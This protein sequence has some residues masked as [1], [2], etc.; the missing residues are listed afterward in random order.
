MKNHSMTFLLEYESE[1]MCNKAYLIHDLYFG[2]V[3]KE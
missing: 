1:F 2:Y 3:V